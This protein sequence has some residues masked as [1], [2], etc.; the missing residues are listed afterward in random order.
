MCQ[1]TDSFSGWS[2]VYIPAN[3][4][5]FGRKLVYQREYLNCIHA[6]LNSVS[7]RVLGR[8]GGDCENEEFY[9]LKSLK[10]RRKGLTN[11]SP[12]ETSSP[13]HL[14]RTTSKIGGTCFY[15]WK[16]SSLE[17]NHKVQGE[18]L[19]STE[20][21]SAEYPTQWKINVEFFI[22]FSK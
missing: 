20:K 11:A 8:G 4:T 13:S 18:T 9:T 14:P 19:C 12:T 6:A 3:Y 21:Q 15:H 16:H 5:K 22:L 2:Q 17:D 1:L 7:C 10:R